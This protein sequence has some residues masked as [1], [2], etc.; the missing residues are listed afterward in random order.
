MLSVQKLLAIFVFLQ[1]VLALYVPPN[2]PSQTFPILVL[3]QTPIATPSPTANSKKIPSQPTG[4]LLNVQ[5]QRVK[6]I[7]FE[8]TQ[9]I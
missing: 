1:A 5:D 7:R 2:Q 3:E 4:L 8:Y 6:A 9:S